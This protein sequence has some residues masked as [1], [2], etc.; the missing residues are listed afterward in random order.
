MPSVAA[1][2]AVLAVVIAAVLCGWSPLL[3]NPGPEAGLVLAVVGGLGL[4]VSQALRGSARRSEGFVADMAFGAGTAAAMTAVFLGSTTIGAAVAATCSP[5]VG[6]LPMLVVS[7]PVLLLQAAVGSFVGRMVG[8]RGAAV[9][10]VVVLEVLALASIGLSLYDEPRFRVASHLFVI[11]SGDLLRGVALPTAAIGFR[12]ATLLLAAL[13]GAVGVALWP[14]QRTRGLASLGPG[15]WMP[16]LAAV[17]LA[18]AFAGAHVTARRA[19]QPT[20]DEMLEAYALV[21]RRDHLVV[22][23]DPLTTTPR[24]VDAILAEGALWLQRLGGRLGPLSSDDIHVFVHA[25]REAEARWT[26]AAHVDFALPWRREVHITTPRAPHRSLGHEL[27]HVVAGE[28]SDTLLRVPAR[29]VVLH[30]AAVTEGVAMA[31]TPELA[32]THG[33]TLQEQAAAMRRSGQA[34]DLRK[35]FSFTRFFA[36]EPGRAYVAAGAL[37]EQLVADAGADA[38]AVIERLYRGE[39]SLDNAVDDVDDLLRRHC[40]RLDATPLPRDALGHAEARFSRP[41]VLDATCDPDAAAAIDD[42]RALARTGDLPGA[43]QRAA[44]LEGSPQQGLADGTLVD[45]VDDVTAAGDA[46]AVVTLLRRLVDQAPAEAERALRAFSLGR[47][48]WR[49]GDERAAVRVWNDVDAGLLDVDTRRQ[50]AA[51]IAFAN[52]ALALGDGARVSRAALAFFHDERPGRTGTRLA[53]AEA[54]G[55]ASATGAPASPAKATGEAAAEPADVVELARYVH[56]RQLL[57]EGALDAAE[58]TLRPVVERATLPPQFH[59][60]A[61]LALGV[62]LVRADR[63]DDAHALFVRAAEAAVRPATRLWLRD[64]AERAARAAK[65]PPSPKVVTATTDPAWADRLLLGIDAAGEL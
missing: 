15:S 14:A 47:A 46:D 31:L 41:S 32:V 52:V 28:K 33:L 34:P 60:Q 61:V 11:V 42:V 43:L 36:E 6:R 19:L 12:G 2:V 9:V 65:A 16:W 64:R 17:V 23:A 63:P 59:E 50:L 25:S 27:A 13:V 39:G 51:V 58:R 62:T 55:A 7:V 24:E 5:G 18:F 3:S 30:A 54:I 37:V 8:R 29:L 57:I 38:P 48:L 56:G 10:A 53:F 20:R 40:T 4:A 35:L 45:L 1:L 26:G 22:H 44:A 49:A 21:K